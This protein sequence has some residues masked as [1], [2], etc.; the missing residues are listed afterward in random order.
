VLEAI[1]EPALLHGS[2]GGSPGRRAHPALAPLNDISAGKQVSLVLEAALR[3][4]F[5]SLDHPWAMRF[6]PLR[7]GEP[8]M[9]TRMRRWRKAGVLRP[10]GARA[11]GESGT[12]QGGRSSVLLSQVYLHD[13]WDVWMEKK[14]RTHLEGE[15]QWGRSLDDCVL[16]FPYRSEALR[17]HQLLEE[18]LKAV[19][20]ALAPA[21]T[22]FIALGRFAQRDAAQQ[23]KSRPETFSFLGFPH[24]CAR[25]RQGN[26]TVERR[27]EHKR[28]P[29]AAQTIQKRIRER[30][31][32]PVHAQQHALTQS[33]R[34][35]Y[36]YDGIAGN[37][38]SLR[39][40]SR[41][42]AKLWRKT[43]SRRSQDGAVRWEKFQKLK[44][45]F[46]L[47][48]PKL[49]ITYAGFQAYAKL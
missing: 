47:V 27:T 13:V 21:K 6:M 34:G 38:Q 32:A 2:C 24:S 18:R 4:F 48:Q 16:C 46:P 43:F 45:R 29:R 33:L 28:Q 22:R 39:R 12:P 41:R 11:A 10:D 8:R 49:S 25:H 40:I 37:I 3:H 5:G 35:H 31:H 19:G 7:V 1:D 30:L 9:L 17:G 26:C 36:T 20:L 14:R 44:Q 23:G 15:A 42:T